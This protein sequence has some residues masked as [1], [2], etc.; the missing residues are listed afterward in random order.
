MIAYVQ[1]AIDSLSQDYDVHVRS[2]M[3]MQGESDAASK[4]TAENYAG[5]EKAFVARVREEFASYATRSANGIRVPG[6]GIIFINSGI[7]SNDEKLSVSAGGPNDWIYASEVNA[8]KISNSQWLCSVLGAE[9]NDPLDRGPLKGYTFGVGKPSI[10]NPDQSNVIPYSIYI[11]TYHFLS[12]A[13]AYENG[14]E[15]YGNESDNKDRAHYSVSSMLALGEFYASCLKFM[16]NQHDVVL[17]TPKTEYTVTYDAN[18]GTVTP[19]SVTVEEG[20]FVTLPTPTR[21]GYTFK[22][23]SDGTTTYAAGANYTVDGNVTL[24]AQWEVAAPVAYKVTVSSNVS[25]VTGVSDKNTAY[26][27]DTITITLTRN[28]FQTSGLTVKVTCSDGTTQTVSF[29]SWQY[30]QEKTV[31]F[32]MPAGD[33]TITISQN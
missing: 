17:V 21:E 30:N 12:K 5:A 23:W 6:S 31:A 7:A 26:A 22:G 13:A 33:V 15:D 25:G 11:D 32:T 19:G 28:G 14:L 20:D 16:A 1:E 18:G 24:T 27:G 8:G 4:N 29:D 10:V 9:T 2:F 3:W